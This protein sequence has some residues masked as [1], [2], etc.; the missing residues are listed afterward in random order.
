[1][2]REIGSTIE[3][4]HFKL[5][6]E[7]TLAADFAERTV[8]D[9]VAGGGH[10]KQFNLAVR[11]QTEQQVPDMVRLPK[12]EAAFTRRDDKPGRRLGHAQDRR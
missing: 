7:E 3:Q 6:R 1:M 9:L 11:V 5:F 8:E 4:R 12:R 10:A 2:H